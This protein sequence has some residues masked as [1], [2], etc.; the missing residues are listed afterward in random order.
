M[1]LISEH[2]SKDNKPSHQ[3]LEYYSDSD[4]ESEE[5][6]TASEE[7]MFLSI[8]YPSLPHFPTP[9]LCNWDISDPDKALKYITKN[10]NYKTVIKCL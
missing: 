8:W 3:E 10:F 5:G 1:C 2:V 9:Y 4:S 7:D 6:S